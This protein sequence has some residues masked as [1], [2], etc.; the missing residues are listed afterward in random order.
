MKRKKTQ[1]A[2]SVPDCSTNYK[3]Q[4]DGYKFSLFQVPRCPLLRQQWQERLPMKGRALLETSSVC[5]LHFARKDVT[6][7]FVHTVCGQEV[8]IPRD[9]PRL[10]E[11]A[12]PL[13]SARDQ[14]RSSCIQRGP[15]GAVQAP[16]LGAPCRESDDIPQME[17]DSMKRKTSEESTCDAHHPPKTLRSNAEDFAMCPAFPHQLPEED[18][19]TCSRGSA[20][21]LQNI[22]KPDNTNW[23][24][25]AVPNV[26]GVFY[27]TSRL[28]VEPFDLYHDKAVLFQSTDQG[29]LSRTYLNGQ[30]QAEKTGLSLADAEAELQRAESLALCRGAMLKKDMQ[31]TE[32]RLSKKLAASLRCHKQVFYSNSCTSCVSEEG[33][34]Y[35]MHVRPERCAKSHCGNVQ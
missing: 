15:Q 2:C 10:A 13:D 32:A 30:L 7:D 18:R 23:A 8:R 26:D 14:Q 19:E 5:E 16:A 31:G 6:R 22:K 1:T 27:V 11:G 35:L 17:C 33:T 9:R 25:L 21:Q 12:L 20:E 4:Q 28:R 3:R 29:I 24:M 34:T